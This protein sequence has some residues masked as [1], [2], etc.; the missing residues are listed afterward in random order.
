MRCFCCDYEPLTGSLFQDNLIDDEEVSRKAGRELLLD[1]P[2]GRYY[3]SECLTDIKNS[4]YELKIL[5][6][7]NEV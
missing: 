1:K 5:N 6:E 7:R 3:C 4:Y 2:T